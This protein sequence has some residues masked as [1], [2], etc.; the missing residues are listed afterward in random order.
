MYVYIRMYHN[1]ISVTLTSSADSVCPGDTVVFTCVSD[2]GRLVWVV[3]NSVDH[4]HSF[5][6]INQIKMPVTE[7]FFKLE[8]VNVTGIHNKT[9]LSTATAHN[10]LSDY[11]GTTITCMDWD[12]TNTSVTLYVLIGEK[13]DHT[14]VNVSHNYNHVQHHLHLHPST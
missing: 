10:V 5:H 14:F 12:Q 8:L 7:Q 9:Y 2:T 1:I 6:S 13:H 4:V 3:N 11:N